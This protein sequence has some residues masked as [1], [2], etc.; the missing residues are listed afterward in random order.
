MG[1]IYRGENVEE[2]MALYVRERINE[3]VRVH[4]L[5]EEPIFGA[6]NVVRV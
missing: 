1:R 6:K 2:G 3:Y 4:I 5:A